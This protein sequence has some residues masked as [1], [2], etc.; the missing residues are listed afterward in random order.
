MLCHGNDAGWSRGNLAIFAHEIHQLVYSNKHVFCCLSLNSE[1]FMNFLSPTNR[2][3]SCAFPG[4]KDLRIK[5]ARTMQFE[6]KLYNNVPLWPH[7]RDTNGTYHVV[8]VMH[9]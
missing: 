7:D 9:C 5:K 2:T 8:T 3:K 6:L 1:F 4:C